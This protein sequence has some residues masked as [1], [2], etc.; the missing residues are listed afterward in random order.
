MIL[1]NI[2]IL[3]FFALSNV[4][5]FHITE[6]SKSYN[7]KPQF[8]S[9]FEGWG[10]NGVDIFFVITGFVLYISNKNDLPSNFIKKR[11]LR[12]VPLYYFSTFKFEVIFFYNVYL[13]MIK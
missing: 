5:L 2:Q 11:F 1:D 10:Q 13:E 4:L 8:F 9:F 12:I 7:Y 6:Y 3:R